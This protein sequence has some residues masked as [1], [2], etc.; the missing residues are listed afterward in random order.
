MSN[1]YPPPPREIDLTAHKSKGS[2]RESQSRPGVVDPAS[3][4][5]FRVS[6]EQRK[7]LSPRT[8]LAEIERKR[9]EKALK[10]LANAA[11]MESTPR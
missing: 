3:Q 10:V 6:I 1:M 4:D 5:F 11:A 2:P 7:L 9:L 8:D